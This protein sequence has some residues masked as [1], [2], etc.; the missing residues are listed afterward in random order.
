MYDIDHKLTQLL[1]IV[2]REPE[3]T[4]A[5]AVNR[6]VKRCT[7]LDENSAYCNLL[8]V[9]HFYGTSVAAES[10]G[11]LLGFVSGYRIPERLETLFVW[12]VAVDKAARGQGLASRMLSDL[13]ARPDCRGI[14][15]LETSITPDN[16]ASLALFRKLAGS[17][18]AE[19]T[20]TEWLDKSA[21][22][23]GQHKSE[24]L[25]RIGPFDNRD[26]GI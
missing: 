6:L 3:L 21:H 20:F 23:D 7:P 8:Q 17:L 25:M 14:R 4:D 22:F 18:S 10:E 26:N 15:F 2:I 11:Q 24:W 1:P 12:Q 13:L 5:M 19:F 9:G 16:E